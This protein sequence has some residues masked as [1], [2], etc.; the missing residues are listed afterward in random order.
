MLKHFKDLQQFEMQDKEN[1]KQEKTP[2]CQQY[3]I[4]ASVSL[5]L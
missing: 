1:D 4:K 2:N 5:E 3:A